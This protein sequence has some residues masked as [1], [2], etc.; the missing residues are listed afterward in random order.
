MFYSS[1]SSGGTGKGNEMTNEN[2]NAVV[3]VATQTVQSNETA[4]EAKAAQNAPENTG[5]QKNIK[6]KQ[7][8]SV[9]GRFWNL[10]LT[11]AVLQIFVTVVLLVCAIVFPSVSASET[12]RTLALVLLAT[13]L[14]LAFF[15]LFFVV[16]SITLRVNRIMMFVTAATV[17]VVSLT[18]F[19]LA[20]RE[21]TL[22]IAALVVGI[23]CICGVMADGCGLLSAKT[24]VFGGKAASKFSWSSLTSEITSDERR[25]SN[26]MSVAVAV[27]TF[28]VMVAALILPI[29][30]V[31]GQRGGANPLAGYNK[32]E[33]GMNRKTV[34]SA[35]SE[36][37]VENPDNTLVWYDKERTALMK[38]SNELSEKI[39]DAQKKGDKKEVLRLAERLE[40]VAKQLLYVPYSKFTV[41]FN[42]FENVEEISYD[43]VSDG[44]SDT[45]AVTAV[46]S[47]VTKAKTTSYGFYVVRTVHYDN[48]S[49]KRF[50]DEVTISDMTYSA[51]F[52]TY[53]VI[54][55]YKLD[56]FGKTFSYTDSY[57]GWCDKGFVNVEY[58]YNSK[59]ANK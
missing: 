59:F 22:I 28:V 26:A 53:T 5:K 17:V 15:N 1:P 42:S 3:E 49:W 35:M 30:N 11:A 25:I 43:F 52:N 16:Q 50:Y 29:I 34:L 2:E 40:E 27:V 56:G 33:L 36:D 23:L 46:E 6:A 12:E 10:R 51:N 8:M 9:V 47:F 54:E 7:P 41:K 21:I 18:G 4:V 37:Y 19:V 44:I 20:C 38:E 32:I 48:G 31:V 55:E 39:V 57:S 13:A 24:M 58:V 14:A 45:P